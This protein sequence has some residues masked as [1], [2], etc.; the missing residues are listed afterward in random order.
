MHIIIY[1]VS[2]VFTLNI[3]LNKTIFLIVVYSQCD[4]D[5]SNATCQCGNGSREHLLSIT[6]EFT[7]ISAII[8]SPDGVINI[9]DQVK[10]YINI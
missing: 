2:S 9:A 5:S 3:K 6:A 7:T 1:C 10:S 4:C 8:A